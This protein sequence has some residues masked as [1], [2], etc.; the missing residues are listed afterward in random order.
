MLR[1]SFSQQY[2]EVITDYSSKH[3]PGQNEEE[4]TSQCHMDPRLESKSEMEDEA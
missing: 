1:E 4:N 3:F 2:E